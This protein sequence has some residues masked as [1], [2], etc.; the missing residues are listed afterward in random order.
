MPAERKL[1]PFERAFT[2]T[3][4]S[5]V[6]VSPDGQ[7]VAYVTGSISKEEG[8]PASTI[9]LV[10]S[11]GGTAR[12]LTSGETGDGS[13]RWSPDGKRMAFVSDRK[14]RGKPQLYLLDLAGGEAVRLSNHEGGAGGQQWSPDGKLLAY[15]SMAGQSDEEKEHKKEHDEH[16]VDEWIKRASLYVIDAP[17]D[18]ASLAADALPEPRR[19]T[20]EDVH[21]GGFGDGGYNWS[22]DSKGFVVVDQQITARRGPDHARDTDL[23]PQWR[24]HEPRRLRDGQHPQVQP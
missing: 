8:P 1:L 16:V 3:I 17:A 14:E 13:P 7:Q 21:V 9:W 12:R 15:C 5:D 24:E 10:P 19:I 2:S 23:R 11:A 18:A 4:I 6:Q 22:P 20:P